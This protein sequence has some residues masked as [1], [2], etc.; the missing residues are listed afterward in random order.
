[1]LSADR[2]YLQDFS[3]RHGIVRQTSLAPF[4][5]ARSI[6]RAI[7]T[8]PRREWG[9]F[10]VGL[11]GAMVC[12]PP[13]SGRY[14]CRMTQAP[15]AVKI[16]AYAKPRAQPQGHMRLERQRRC[17]RECAWRC[18]SAML[19]TVQCDQDAN[20]SPRRRRSIF[21]DPL[22]PSV[23]K[24]RQ[25]PAEQVKKEN[26]FKKAMRTHFACAPCSRRF[27]KSCYPTPRFL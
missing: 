22:E 25:C 5:S 18:P 24:K 9:D 12:L 3:E 6:V 23:E 16:T 10:S 14:A 4:D 1:R 19:G 17:N 27:G 21:S 7:T 15:A 13:G 2:L 8:I 26:A 11:G 20:V